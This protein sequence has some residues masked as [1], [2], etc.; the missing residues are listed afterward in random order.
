LRNNRSVPDTVDESHAWPDIAELERSQRAEYEDL[1]AGFGRFALLALVAGAVTGLVAGLFRVVLRE[2]NTLR[3]EAAHALHPLG[4]VGVLAAMAAVAACAAFARWLVRFSPEAAGSGVQRVE[5]VMHGQEPPA[6]PRVVPVKFVG[7]AVALGSGLVLGREGPSVQ[8]GAT[9]GG[10]LAKHARMAVVDIERMQTATAGAGLGVAFGAPIGGALFALEEVARVFALRLA[11]GVLLASAA[12]LAVSR[13]LLGTA[14]IYRVA[15]LPAPQ[16]GW[17]IPLVLLA[18]LLGAAAVLYNRAVV[19]TLDR[20][21]RI[22]HVAPEAKAAVIGAL[23]GLVLAAGP[24]LVGGG[25]GLDQLVL[26]GGEATL[27]LVGILALRG[28]LGPLSYAA[29][30]PGGLFAPLLLLGSAAGFL[31]ATLANDVVPSLALP[32]AAF[33][34]IGMATFFSGV[35]R[36]PLTGV[37]LLVEMTANTSQAIPMLAGAAIAAVAASLLG[38][39]P[40]YDTLRLRTLRAEASRRAA[41]SRGTTRSKSTSA[42]E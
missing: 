35:V 8:M 24:N 18:V 27:A 34:V 36:A 22:R 7:G 3:G 19:E 23:V 4:V 16:W 21:E 2:L 5:A 41:Q 14:P 25:D 30:T 13:W 31:F 38:G 26:N 9:I 29:G 42:P 37:A 12:A 39:A 15:H 33:A 6:P 1:T 10:W 20:V 28:V 32:P 40:I 17:A 11:V